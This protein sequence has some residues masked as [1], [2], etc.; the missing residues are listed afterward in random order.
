[1]EEI[2]EIVWEALKNGAL[3]TCLVITLMLLIEYLYIENKGRYLANLKVSKVKQIALACVLGIIPG[4][5]GGFA[6]VS[7]YTHGILCFG[8]LCSAMICSL[9]DE[10]FAIIGTMP[11]TYLRLIGTLII[12][13]IVTGFVVEAARNALAKK[14]AETPHDSNHGLCSTQY[15]IHEKETDCVPSI[16]KGSSYAVLRTPSKERIILLIGIILFIAAL[17]TGILE[18]HSHESE[19]S[20]NI[21]IFREQWLNYIFGIVSIFTLLMTATAKEHFIK[22]HIWSHIIK[23]HLIM[24]FLWTFVALIVC[25]IITV[26]LDVSR[27]ISDY[28]PA[29]ILLAALIGLIPES[30]PHLIF[31]VLCASGALPFYVLLAS[32]VSQQGHVSLPLLAESK[33]NWLC[34]KIICAAIAFTAGMCAMMLSTL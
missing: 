19:R 26:N 14:K 23:K 5:I 11:L 9:G 13:A 8:A 33:K 28:M 20:G 25:K 3:I 2:A 18:E 7:L 29:V 30:G 10:S 12:I 31:V 22:E 27:Y 17:F 1:M 4:C 24:I 21:N 16:F 34:A 6:A 15:E 32:S